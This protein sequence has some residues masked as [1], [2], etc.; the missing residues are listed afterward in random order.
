MRILIFLNIDIYATK[1]QKY[2]IPI[3]VQDFEIAWFV[4]ND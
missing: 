3:K 2:L 1:A 4:R